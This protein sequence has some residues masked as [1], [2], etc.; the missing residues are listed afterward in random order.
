MLNNMF[1]YVSFLNSYIHLQPETLSAIFGK[2]IDDVR[3]ILEEELKILELRESIDLRIA[4]LE[5]MS[6]Y[7]KLELDTK[8]GS[9][10]T[11]Q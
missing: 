9:T 6:A 4:E 7:G 3:G 11:L 2:N 8:V 1:Q 5:C 10:S